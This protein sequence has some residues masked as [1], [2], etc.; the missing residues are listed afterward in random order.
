MLIG[1]GDDRHQKG[2]SFGT[3]ELVAG[4]DTRFLEIIKTGGREAFGER[5]PGKG[6]AEK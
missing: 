3:F 6:A 5:A 2:G 1:V 4:D